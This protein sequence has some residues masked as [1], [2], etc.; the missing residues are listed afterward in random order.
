MSELLLLTSSRKYDNWQRV[1]HLLSMFNQPPNA[2]QFFF[3][4]IDVPDQVELETID[5]R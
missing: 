1:G 5:M 2:A 3:I 4:W